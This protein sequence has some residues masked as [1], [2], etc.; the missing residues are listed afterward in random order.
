MLQKLDGKPQALL[1]N[2]FS[3]M[4]RKTDFGL[5][6]RNSAKEFIL[7]SLEKTMTEVEAHFLYRRIER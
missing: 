5:K 7:E 6:N 3:F 1:D 4:R 2:V